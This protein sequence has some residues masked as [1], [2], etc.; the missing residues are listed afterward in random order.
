MR[1]L[2]IDAWRD[3]EDGWQWNAW[4]K[5]GTIAKSELERI[6]REEGFLKWYIINGYVD[7]KFPLEI[8]DDGYN[9]VVQDKETSEPLLAIEYGNCY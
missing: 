2:S 6:E 1:V 8:D 3:S 7:E 9:I 4:Y 5:V